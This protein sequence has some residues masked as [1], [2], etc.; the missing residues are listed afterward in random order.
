MKRFGYVISL[1]LIAWVAGCGDTTAPQLDGLQGVEL[2][3]PTILGAIMSDPMPALAVHPLRQAP[4]APALDK[5]EFSFW[6]VAGEEV[7]VRV[8][9]VTGGSGY[10]YAEPFMRFHIPRKGLSAYPD[11]TSFRN[12]DSVLIE[13]KID[14]ETFDVDF[15]PD[16]LLFDDRN[17]AII[18]MWYQYADRDLNQD[19]KLTLDD[20][21]LLRVALSYWYRQ[22]MW[23]A[24]YELY[25]EHDPDAEWIKTAIRHFSGYA[26]SWQE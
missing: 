7:T 15:G 24:W 16:G 6:A 8:N 18:E 9:Y 3:T 23:S 10:I 26:V 1:G 2:E 21:A 13:V 25:S 4:D 12:G 20:A 11:G 14:E 22:S 19:A 17:P 5:Y